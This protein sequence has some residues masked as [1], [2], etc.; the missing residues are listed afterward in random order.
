MHV[1]GCERV[2]VSV[3]MGVGIGIGMG[4]GIGI[5]ISIGIGRDLQT[6][7]SKIK[8]VPKWAGQ[9]GY[10][11]GRQIVVLYTFD[12]R[13]HQCHKASHVGT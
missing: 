13:L 5:G 4:K 11:A 7:I 8:A 12:Q 2:C 1:Y 9:C 3:G 10:P 6:C